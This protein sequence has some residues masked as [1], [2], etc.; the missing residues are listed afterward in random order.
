MFSNKDLKKIIVPLIIE[1]LLGISVGMFDTIMI[2]TLGESAVSGVSLVDMLNV[3]MINIFAALA[4]GGAVV[5]A[6]ELGRV[7]K[8]NESSN[9]TN[10][11]FSSAR[12]AAKQLIFVLFV[13]S[14]LIAVIAYFFRVQLLRL[15]FG[16]IDDDVMNF[17]LTYFVIST[18]SY[19]FIAV[20]NGLAALFRTMGN[21]GVTMISSLLMNIIN[22]IGNALFIFVFNWG[23]AGAAISTAISRF[24][25][26]FLLFVLISNKRNEIFISWKE[27]IYIDTK[28]CE[29]I[30]RI[31]IPG[32]LENSVF[33][34]GRILVIS[35]IAGFG[36]VQVAANAVANNLDSLGCI[37][38]QAL[39]LAVI[40]VVGQ[41]IG[42]GDNNSARQYEQKIL[43]ISF[44]SM[45]VVNILIIVTLPL[46]LKLYNLS[47]D[48]LNLAT[49]LVLLHN[50]F[51][52]LLWP[53]AFVLPN[54]LRAAQ[55][56][57]FTMVV[58]IFSMIAFRIFFTWVIGVRFGMG[59]IGVW[60]AMILDWVFRG[61]LFVWRIRSGRWLKYVSGNIQQKG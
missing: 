23:V 38:G 34:L 53:P 4:T 14:T 48:T 49:I 51:A 44:A 30:L 59:I 17:A 29:K 28:I 37:P 45:A 36:T 1:Q 47:E 9:C 33:Q 20:Y 7:K 5:C 16:S 26:M 61:A 2:S 50:G 21:S 10:G 43:K 31:G 3:L 19:P 15:C 46:S 40:T 58:S 6:Y 18:I 22:I 54:A 39:G 27:K 56:V 60:I 32:S 25:G 42:A 13:A 12:F 55:D 11:D 35:M 41:C 24:I 8:Q 57:K 52:I